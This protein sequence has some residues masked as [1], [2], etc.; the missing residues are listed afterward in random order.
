V[1]NVIGISSVVLEMKSPIRAGLSLLV[2]FL[3]V[4]LITP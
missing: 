4:V 1:Y 2:H 3:H